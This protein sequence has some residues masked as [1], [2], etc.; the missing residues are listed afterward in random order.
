V[1]NNEEVLPPRY[2]EYTEKELERKYCPYPNTDRDSGLKLISEKHKR[3]KHPLC[4][5]HLNSRVVLTQV[6]QNI[7]SGRDDYRDRGLGPP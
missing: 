6:L 3:A 4:I 5:T 2:T 1:V 7:S